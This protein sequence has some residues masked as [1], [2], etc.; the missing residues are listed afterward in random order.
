MRKS[1]HRLLRL[2]DDRGTMK[3]MAIAHR[4]SLWCRVLVPHACNPSYSGGRD[5][6]IVLQSQPGQ[7]VHETLSQKK[8]NNA[9][10]VEWL[11]W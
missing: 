4:V 5:Q 11:K 6:E 10:L 7:I 2:V 9:G 3:A 8:P 1:V